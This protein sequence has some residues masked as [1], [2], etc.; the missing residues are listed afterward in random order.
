MKAS[1]KGHRKAAVVLTT[2]ALMLATLTMGML[3]NPTR[4]A[5]TTVTT[6][7]ALKTALTATGTNTIVVG[8]NITITS[9]ITIPNNAINTLTANGAY[10]LTKSSA[11][12]GVLKLNSGAKLTIGTDSSERLV[13]DGNKKGA[14]IEVNSGTLNMYGGTIKNGQS[15][16]GGGIDLNG[17][18]ST[19]GI[20]NMYGGTISYNIATNGGST[21]A[22]GG[23]LNLGNYSTANIYAGIFCN[24]QAI[25]GSSTSNAAM[26]G[27]IGTGASTSITHIY[28]PV[29]SGNKADAGGGG[30][31]GCDVGGVKMMADGHTAIFNNAIGSSPYY[32]TNSK[33][34][35]ISKGSNNTFT[36]P[37]TMFDGTTYGWGTTNAVGSNFEKTKTRSDITFTHNLT[38]DASS[39]ITTLKTKFPAAKVFIVNNYTNGVGGGVGANGN[40]VYYGETEEPPVTPGTPTPAKIS[41]NAKKTVSAAAGSS[42]PSGSHNFGMTL[43][44]SDVNAAQGTQR[45]AVTVT[46]TATVVAPIAYFNDIEY[47]AAGTHY[48]LVKETSAPTGWSMDAT[49]Y[50]IRVVVA[51]DSASNSYTVTADYRTGTGGTWGSWKP[52]SATYNPTGD[53][54]SSMTGNVG[55]KASYTMFSKLPRNTNEF[56]TEYQASKTTNSIMNPTGAANSR[57]GKESALL[58]ALYPTNTSL[59]TAEFNM[60]FGTNISTAST[61]TISGTAANGTSHSI[62]SHPRRDFV[63]EAARLYEAKIQYPSLNLKSTVAPGTSTAGATGSWK[64][65]V[66]VQASKEHYDELYYSFLWAKNGESHTYLD[67]FYKLV[68]NMTGIINQHN[69]GTTTSLSMSYT[70]NSATSGT[71]NV[72]HN[73]WVS[74]NIAG[75]AQHATKLNWP[76]TT[77]WS[78]KVGSAAAVTNGVTGVTV[79]DGDT[80]TVT[81][82]TG[83]PSIAFTLTD[84][85]KYVKAKSIKGSLFTP[86]LYGTLYST[87]GDNEYLAGCAQFVTLKNTLTVSGSSGTQQGTA[88]NTPAE[89]TRYINPSA[90]FTYIQTNNSSNTLWCGDM[91]VQDLSLTF[92]NVYGT[93]SYDATIPGAKT[94]TGTPAAS[95]NFVFTLTHASSSGTATAIPAGMTINGAASSPQTR[96]VTRSTAGSDNFQFDIAGLNAGDTRYFT[97]SETTGGSGGSGTWTNATNQ[98]LIQV[99]V[100]SNGTV[101]YSHKTRTTAT[102]S[103]SSSW[104]SGWPTTPTSGRCG[105]SNTYTATYGATIPGT[106]SLAGT[107]TASQNFVFTLTHANSSGTATA[108]PSGMTISGTG[109]GNTRTVIV[110][111][112][113][114]GSSGFQFNIAGLN[115]GDTRYFTLVETTGGSGGSGTWTNA[116]NQ[117]LIQVSVSSTGVVSYSYKTR[118]SSSASWSS[119]W[120]NGTPSGSSWSWVSASSVSYSGNYLVP[121]EAGASIATGTINASNV[122]SNIDKIIN[123]AYC[124]DVD[125][126]AAYVD[127]NH[128]PYAYY[129]PLGSENITASTGGMGN[130]LLN[131][132]ANRANTLWVARN[133]FWATGVLTM[134][135]NNGLPATNMT[136][137]TT[138]GNYDNLAW[139]NQKYGA[140]LTQY[141]AFMAT[142]FAVWRFSNGVNPASASALG[143]YKGLTIPI[144]QATKI[145]DVYTKMVAEAQSGTTV[146]P[147]ISLT[148][149]TS[150]AVITSGWYGPIKA[151]ATPDKFGTTN[152]AI[153]LTRSGTYTL[154]KSASGGST[155]LSVNSGENFYINLGSGV[156]TLPSGALVTAKASAVVTV[157]GKPG[158]SC[159]FVYGN[160]RSKGQILCGVDRRANCKVTAEA[161][162]TL[163]GGMFNFENKYASAGKLEIKKTVTGTG[164]STSKL[165]SFT[166][167]NSS[168]QVVNLTQNGIAVSGNGTGSNLANGVVT[169]AHNG[170]ITVSNLPL[171]TYYVTENSETGYTTT[172]NITG[173]TSGSTLKSGN[174][175]IADGGTSTVTFTNKW[176]TGKLE[177]KKTVT[178][179]GGDTAKLFSFTVYNSSGTAVNLTQNS[180][181]VTGHGTGSS[182]ASGVVR[183]AHN[184][185]IAISNLPVGTYYVVENG[186][187]GYIATWVITG[188]TSGSTSRSDNMT[189]ADGGTSTVTFTN[190][191]L[192][193]GLTITKTVIGGDLDKL[194]SFV[195]KNSSGTAVNLTQSGV[196]VTPGSGTGYSLASGIIA[197]KHN[198]SVTITGLPEGTYTVTETTTGYTTTYK[199]NSG[200]VT[201]GTTAS[202][203]VSDGGSA[204]AEFTNTPKPTDWKPGAIKNTNVNMKIN[205]FTFQLWKSNSPGTKD[206]SA[207]QTKTNV[208]GSAISSVVNF[209]TI[210][211]TTAGEHF[212]LLAETASTEAN[213]TLDTAQYLFKVVV[214]DVNGTLTVTSITFGKYD[215]VAKTFTDWKPFDTLTQPTFT[216]TY[217]E[218]PGTLVIKKTVTGTGGDTAKRFSFTV[219]NSSGQPVN[220]TTGSILVNLPS[221][222]GYNLPNGVVAMA[223][224]GTV[225]I[226]NLPAGTYYVTENSEAGYTTTWNITGGSNGSGAQSGNIA[227]GGG[228]TAT[229]TFTNN[230]TPQTGK[231][232]IKKSVTGTGSSSAKLFS[233]TVYNSSNQPVN[234]TQSGITVSGQGAGSNLASG[235]VTV[236]HNGTITVSNLPIGT[237]YV[238]ENSETGY[239][240]T[241]NITGGTNGSGGRSGDIAVTGNNTSTVTFTNR[242]MTGKLEIKK[243]VTG[244]DTAKLFSF[245]V[246]NSSNQPVNLTQNGITVSGQGT[247]SNLAS[248]VVTVPH[249]GTI[250]IS[251]LPIGTY[252]VTE[253]SETGYTTTWSTTGGGSG[254]TLKSGDMTIA[255]GETATVTFTNKLKSGGLTISKTVVGGDL[256]KLFNFVVK[257]SGGAAVNLSQSGIAVSGQ[258]A[259][260]NLANGLVT[261]KHNGSVTITGLPE[262]TYTVTETT[263][264]YT[265]TYKVNSGAETSGTVASVAVAD[266]GAATVEFINTP[267]PTSWKPEATKNTN[268]NM[269]VNQFTFQLWKSND[270]GAKDGAAL[271][272]KTNA[273]G[274]AISSVVN[275]DT[276]PLTAAG[277]YYYLLTEKPKEP[278]TDEG[279]TY[280]TEQYLFKVVVVDVNGKLEKTVTYSSQSKGFT[281]WKAFDLATPPDFKN[282]YEISPTTWNPNATKNATGKEMAKDQFA[283]AFYQSNIDGVQGTLIENRTN[284]AG[285][286]SALSFTP[287]EYDF[288]K[289]GKHYYIMRETTPIGDG[290]VTDGRIYHFEVVVSNNGDGTLKAIATYRVKGPDGWSEEWSPYTA[291]TSATWPLFINTAVVFTEELPIIVNK[292]I[293]GKNNTED[294]FDFSLTEVIKNPAYPGS[295]QKEYIDKTSGYTETIKVTVG[296]PG[297]FS[298]PNLEVGTYYYRI[299]EDDTKLPGWSYDES[300]YIVTV[301]ITHGEDGFDAKVIYPS[302]LEGLTFNNIFKRY[303]FKFTKTDRQD[304]PLNQ[305][306]F[307]LYACKHADPVVPMAGHTKHDDM[308]NDDPDCCWERYQTAVSGESGKTEEFGLVSFKDLLP[309]D[310]ILIETKTLPGYQLPMGQ[311]L[312]HI[313]IEGKVSVEAKGDE[314]PPAF[315]VDPETKALSLPNYPS[316]DMPMTGGLTRMLLSVA[317]T[318]LLG[319]VGLKGTLNFRAKR[320]RNSGIAR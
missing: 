105:F 129:T 199:V 144:A 206:G 217:N 162:M 198:G 15:R 164:G 203:S 267:Q 69:A 142:Q 115:A 145:F 232:E 18:S 21:D 99:S 107:P 264:G 70:H 241:W 268:V 88:G 149:D 37:Q 193:G 153:S 41:I 246:Y 108:I 155:T 140:S 68:D 160:D 89:D 34:V 102:G 138:G 28:D 63:R 1:L 10:A 57:D 27:A 38:T 266:G 225:T 208:Y 8:A 51:L 106:K 262:G 279:W 32:T 73:G 30:I 235:L 124:A 243:L 92:N 309:G 265:T 125:T 62:P 306:E 304:A 313:D 148:F 31:H 297:F 74:K 36:V 196:T 230:Y 277:S 55:T 211:L 79:N 49:Q 188:G 154:S 151:T 98:Y 263:T 123:T 247:G 226:S 91:N 202:V 285:A 156:T 78:V 244:G 96:T 173:G 86:S 5:T 212:F 116:A 286:T 298:L 161:E 76:T 93:T 318:I 2:L 77:G 53:A 167:Y 281:D 231:L 118:A 157:G 292:D 310:Y 307:Q 170:T 315:K 48:Y 139:L 308:V 221:G 117:Y 26:G 67:Y 56:P 201:T 112:S 200:T 29:I 120:T 312:I 104:T 45:Q 50:H 33:D 44:N 282:E 97:L 135:P 172:W 103:W 95:Q 288:A 127:S 250:T 195:V 22:Y 94:L 25:G 319:L 66:T 3:V 228:N 260:S 317:G 42:I 52:Y 143:S 159:L 210:P 184:G 174:M 58:N 185:T 4:T 23:G 100:A 131:T 238:T 183:A 274:S 71:I 220:L 111:M 114:A 158:E 197:I 204:M 130:L 171:G 122:P 280:S 132:A 289:I 60:L 242:W 218:P 287:I 229:V 90:A 46:R 236:A 113:A 272:T 137:S 17:S 177:I 300:E 213:W 275:F 194:F 270:S 176:Q 14:V 293:T 133:G 35:A 59:T 276:I 207:L 101:S 165:F 209:D 181:S 166:V 72:S 240:T 255:D 283:F 180:I 257:N 245:T 126:S 141:E 284:E 189:I 83:S 43:Y 290:W 7:T 187:T 251:N 249:N 296:T 305:V 110:P 64:S 301:T 121:N 82:P 9:T 182:L 224:N 80:I 261:M 163:G 227:V 219:Y 186:E 54:A 205:Q 128:N 20:F 152:V 248:G 216:N 273:Y 150:G 65:A 233:F 87:G 47:T 259:G 16:Y 302:G 84:S 75:V 223:H 191:R 147:E 24:N 237:Y 61:Q 19:R 291:E 239:T 39:F 109:T 314:T 81:R 252:Y 294:K 178:G 13:I 316:F 269:K 192:S 214:A 299:T 85:A 258:G 320:K 295:N 254:S 119:S 215:D 136:W 253:N 40:Q 169:V 190:R 179:T 11:S 146:M 6:E 12:G 278:G 271:Q 168:N 311:W 222:S 256:E 175:T 303:G 134:T 234:L